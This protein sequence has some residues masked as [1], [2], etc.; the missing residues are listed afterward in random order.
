MARNSSGQLSFP[1]IYQSFFCSRCQ[2]FL[3]DLQRWW[4]ILWF[5]LST[6]LKCVCCSS[7]FPNLWWDA[8]NSCRVTTLQLFYGFQPRL[9]CWGL[10]QFTFQRCCG[11]QSIA[12]CWTVWQALKSDFRWAA[13]PHLHFVRG[14]LSYKRDHIRLSR[15]G[16]IPC[17]H[18]C[19]RNGEFF[20]QGWS[21]IHSDYFEACVEGCCMQDGRLPSYVSR[22]LEPGELGGL[23]FF[24]QHFLDFFIVLWRIRV[25]LVE[26]QSWCSTISHLEAT[27][28]QLNPSYLD[29]VFSWKFTLTFAVWR[30]H[31]L[32]FFFGAHPCVGLGLKW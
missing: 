5:A 15:L 22:K 9:Q 30:L 19:R 23:I 18:R 3:L 25:S 13:L 6:S 14:S 28:L 1:R 32:S 4:I 27:L 20:L 17:S 31:T 10:V 2:T 29:R 26:K 21:T 24:S 7:I 11:M 16:R 12:D 8:I